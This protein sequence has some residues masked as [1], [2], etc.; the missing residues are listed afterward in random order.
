MWPSHATL[1]ASRSAHTFPSSCHSSFAG[2]LCPTPRSAPESSTR[3]SPPR[4][5]TSMPTPN[6]RQQKRAASFRSTP[7]ASRMP[8]Y[9][10][11]ASPRCP[12][13]CARFN[14]LFLTLTFRSDRRCRCRGIE[15][16]GRRA[17]VPRGAP[18]DCAVRCS[19][20]AEGDGATRAREDSR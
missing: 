15:G 16:A 2:S 13:W 11:V 18:E 12:T 17:Q 1:C 6:R 7:G 14:S 9:R 5:P 8:C 4:R 20:S 3:S 10:T 19:A